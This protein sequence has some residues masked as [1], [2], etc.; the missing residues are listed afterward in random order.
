LLDILIWHGTTIFTAH[1]FFLIPPK[2]KELVTTLCAC[3]APLISSL[4]PKRELLPYVAFTQFKDRHQE[5]DMSEGFSEVRRVN[6]VFEGTVEDKR[7]WS[8]WLQITS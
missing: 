5:P 2:N 6:F 4:Q 7:A 8:M 1:T 3:H